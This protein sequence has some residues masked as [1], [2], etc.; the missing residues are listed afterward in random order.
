M[1]VLLDTHKIV[2]VLENNPS[3]SK[4]H[5]YIISDRSNEKSNLYDKMVK[6]I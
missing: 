4:K 2:W 1:K 6:I 3:I 5:T